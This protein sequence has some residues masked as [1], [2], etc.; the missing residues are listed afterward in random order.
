M[1]TPPSSSSSPPSPSLEGAAGGRVGPP[2]SSSSSS[3][4]RM[5]SGDEVWPEPFIE[6]LALRVA[7]D[8]SRNLGRL[9]SAQA[10]S[11][12]FQVCS[13]WHATS[14]SDLLWRH[15]TQRVWNADTL[16]HDSWRDE[17]IHRHRTANNFRLSRAAYT[18]LYF[19][20][21]ANNENNDGLACRRLALSDRHL[22]AG[23]A[24][25]AVHL[26][27]LPDGAHLSAFHPTPRQDRLGRFSGAV[28]GIVLT[29]VRV[30]FAT[31]GGD[32]HVA[33]LGDGVGPTPPLRRAYA[34]DVVNDGVLV[35]FT[36]CE[37]WWVGLYAGTC[38]PG[39]GLR[40]WNRVTEELVFVG[41]TLTDPEAVT[42][43]HMLTEPTQP[44]GRVRITSHG[45]MAVAC[46][47]VRV[48]VFDLE[49]H[50][51]MILGEEEFQ[52]EIIVGSFDT[53]NESTLMVDA[54]G[55]AT[56]R[57]VPTLEES[58]GF[59]VRGSRLGLGE[60]LGSVNGGYG[61]VLV[62]GVVKVWDI[63]VGRYLYRFRETIGDCSAL[64]T[65]DRYVA[66]YSTDGTIHL[67]D[68]G[69]S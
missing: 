12:I 34:G 2:A 19:Y 10:L 64:V 43:W 15:L 24:N 41:G 29:D 37:R 66:A 52:R 58:C 45:R 21:A 44:I 14:W 27:R 49:S 51:G 16:L 62:N 22:A 13:T 25:G 17:Y 31:L 40:V 6:A 69:L 28:A 39:H 56:I 20:P 38:V 48:I 9:Y 30:V 55:S 23:F 65:D 61:V 8:A 36:G 54:R 53:V 59:L 42:G 57:R 5:R 11:N 18:P 35:D 26:Y 47:S 32:V 63:E 68:F 7:T 33:N 3:R 46:T 67:W 50:V 1:S 60:V 4:S